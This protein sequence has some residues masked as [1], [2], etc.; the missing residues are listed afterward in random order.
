MSC[1]NRERQACFN[2]TPAEG[3]DAEARLQPNAQALDMRVML[4]GLPH[5]GSNVL[6]A[7]GWR[8]VRALRET[9]RG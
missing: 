4:P 5:V 8:E 7:V 1:S 3:Q 9:G 6:D 2:R